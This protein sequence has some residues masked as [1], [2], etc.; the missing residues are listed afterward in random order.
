MMMSQSLYRTLKAQHPDAVIDVMAPAWCRPLLS[1]MPE[2]SQALAMP[3][4]H[5]ALALGERRR[6]GK[7][8]RASGYAVEYRE[9]DGPHAVP[10]DVVQQ[11]LAW[12]LAQGNDIVPIP[13]TRKVNRLEENV[14][15]AEVSLTQGDL[16]RIYEI[17]PNGAAGARY[18]AALMPTDW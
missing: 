14:A 6:I 8:L 13:G 2:V 1:R 16:D 18:P 4:G 5:G 10:P 15:A 3:L 7:S 9:F 12:L 11:A 17:L